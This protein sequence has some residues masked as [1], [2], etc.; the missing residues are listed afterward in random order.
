[1]TDSKTRK[2]NGTYYRRKEEGLCV[3]CGGPRGPESIV[4]HCKE[5]SEHIAKVAKKRRKLRVKNGLCRNCGK[6]VE[7][8]K[9]M[10]QRCMDAIKAASKAQR[11]AWKAS[12]MCCDCGSPVILNNTMFCQK[13]WFQKTAR[14]R[15]GSQKY[16]R[17]LIKKL[18]DQH[19]T[20]PYTGVR[21][22]PGENAWLDH[23]YP[24]SRFPEISSDPNNVEWVCREINEMKR[25]R[26]RAEFLDYITHI[27]E[28]TSAFEPRGA[29][30]IGC[31]V[32]SPGSSPL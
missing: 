24:V 1:M 13:C 23:I 29:N 6:P 31:D 19:H 17:L 30:V 22:I 5:C 3:R 12:G 4:L 25:D 2:D 20:C 18:E 32:R 10:C 9:A 16:W 27:L 8:G 11:E 26:T 14:S 21:L 15:L 28:Y 7:N